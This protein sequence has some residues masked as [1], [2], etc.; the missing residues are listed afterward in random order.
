[1]RF[2]FYSL[3][4][5]FRFMQFNFGWFGHAIFKDGA[6]PDEM[7]SNIGTDWDVNFNLRVPFC[8]P[9]IENKFWCGI[10]ICLIAPN[11]R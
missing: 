1:M 7:R 5:L 11:I 6:Y 10:F 3:Y 9:L 8:N 2:K 4:L